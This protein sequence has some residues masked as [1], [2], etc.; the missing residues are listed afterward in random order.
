MKQSSQTATVPRSPNWRPTFIIYS[1]EAAG[2][3]MMHGFMLL[4][5]MPDKRKPSRNVFV[6]FDTP[7]MQNALNDWMNRR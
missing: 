4:K 6:F 7:E 3:L 2:Y 5:I 1:Q